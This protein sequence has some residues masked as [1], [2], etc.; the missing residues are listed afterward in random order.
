MGYRVTMSGFLLY[1]YLSNNYEVPHYLGVYFYVISFGN[2]VI[3]RSRQFIKI[4][5]N[6]IRGLPPIQLGQMAEDGLAL[7]KIDQTIPC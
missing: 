3:V 7:R 5:G 6:E 4:L 2:D 1:K